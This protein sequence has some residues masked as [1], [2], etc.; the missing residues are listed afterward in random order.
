MRKL[1]LFCLMFIT[2]LTIL[3]TIKNEEFEPYNYFESI[4]KDISNVEKPIF[5]N[6]DLKTL[7]DFKIENDLKYLPSKKLAENNDIPIYN[8]LDTNYWRDY[9]S[10]YDIS[11]Y[12]NFDYV[13]YYNSTNNQGL[14]IPVYIYGEKVTITIDYDTYNF[15]PLEYQCIFECFSNDTILEKAFNS[16]VGFLKWLAQFIKLL[17]DLLVY[18]VKFILYVL[19]VVFVLGKGVIS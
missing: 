7:N 1:L 16:I 3:F 14:I 10:I 11:N 18:L 2:A 6:F 5:P 13:F 15:V 8:S 4:V 19:N 12:Q 9:S 17:F